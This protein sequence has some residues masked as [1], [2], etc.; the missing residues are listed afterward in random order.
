[1]IAE[2]VI[3]HFVGD[4]LIQSHWMATEKTKRWLP[5]VVHAVTYTLPFLLIT[6]S[7]WALAVICVTH[8]VIDR[9]RLA[10]HVCWLKNQAAPA[11]HRPR[12]R[13]ASA[14]GYPSDTPAWL[15]V[16]LLII[17]DNTLHVLINSAALLLLAN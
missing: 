12:W 7:P 17:A 2:G 5:A 8:A 3:A 11:S 10:R 15:S 16:W 4:Y 1:V 9:Y 6:R 13:D 14:T